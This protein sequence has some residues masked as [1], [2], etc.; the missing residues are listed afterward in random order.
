VNDLIKFLKSKIFWKHFAYAIGGIIVGIN[1]ILLILKLYTHH[2]Q[3]LS[4][5]EFSGLSLQEA[6]KVALD[7]GL[8]LQV[9]DSVYIQGKPG[10]TIV[11]QNPSPSLKVKSNR[12]I[13]ITLN[14]INAEK[15]EVPNVMGLSLRQAE[16][17]IET[18]GLKLGITSYVPDVAVNY[19]L[20][21][22]YR[23]R[24]ITPNTKINK[25]SRI[26]LV[27]GMGVSNEQSALPNLVGLSIDNARQ[28]LSQ[29]IL[30]FGAIVYDNS[31]ETFDDSIKAVIWR[32][33]PEFSPGNTINLGSS[34][35]VYLTVD[36]SK[37]N[38]SDST[39]M[40]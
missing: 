17:I 1:V 23:N 26:D 36:Q 11:A 30:N 6:Q 4:V 15:V 10:G 8:R 38:K 14:A 2:G 40:N 25:G 19:V 29:A 39:K 34:I 32:Q 13:F 31:V 37:V 28:T 33:K 18:R 9:I 3:A 22:L 20:K 35:D 27:V 12:I 24:E 7:Q 21:Q 5:P 16:A